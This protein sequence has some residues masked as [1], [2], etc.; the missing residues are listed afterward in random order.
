MALRR[1]K[2]QLY[3]VVPNTAAVN[4]AKRLIRGT[5]KEVESKLRGEYEVRV[6]T[7]EETHA[8]ADVEIEDA[9]GEPV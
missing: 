6:A 5:L 8:M 1:N 2:T 4:D 3:I 7:A 9:A